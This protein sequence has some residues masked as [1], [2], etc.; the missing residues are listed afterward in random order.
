[1]ATYVLDR[2][3]NLK[4]RRSRFRPDELPAAGRCGS[5]QWLAHGLH[6]K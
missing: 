4:S 3:Q 6:H 1:M 5:W 2:W